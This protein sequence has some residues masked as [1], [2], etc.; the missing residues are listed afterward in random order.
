MSRA[1][2]WPITA[3]CM[4]WAGLGSTLAPTSRRTVKRLRFGTTAAMAGRSTPGSTPITN[5][6]MAMAAPVLPADTKADASPSLT[7]WAATR[8]DESRLRRSACEALSPMLTTWEAC[9][10]STLRTHR[11]RRH[12][13][14]VMRAA[15]A[16]PRLA[17]ASFR[18]RHRESFLSSVMGAAGEIA[19][20]GQPGVGRSRLTRAGRRV[21]VDPAD[22][23]QP[24]TLRPAQRLHRKRQRR[25]G[26]DEHVQVQL[27]VVVEVEVQVVGT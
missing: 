6:A 20:R 1:Y 2:T 17:V 12:G 13:E 16:A 21:A 24:A 7:S 11:P 25:F 8:R 14:L 5:M 4:R 10:L 26:L 15:L 18:Q 22:G 9:R 23:A 19:E 3:N 27:V